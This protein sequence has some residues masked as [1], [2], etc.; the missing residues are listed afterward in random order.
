MRDATLADEVVHVVDDDDAVRD[1][2]LLL[3]RASGFHAR[4]Y[5]DP[6]AFLAVANS[7]QAGCVLLD[8]RM[9]GKSGLQVQAELAALGIRLPVIIITGHGDVSAARSAFLRGA[10]DFL[11]KPLDDGVLVA[12]MREALQRDRERRERS[13]GEVE[14]E[15]RASRLTPREREVMVL[16]CEGHANHEIASRLAISVRTVEVHK[17][18]MM[19][20]LEV[21]SLADLLRIVPPARG[22]GGA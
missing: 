19:A 21:D 4:G 11:E 22:V 8:L 14:F 1:S 17:A 10:V 18:R 12:A 13:A 20:K 2:L 3:L 7:L 15:I 5:A 6:V 9:P 16:V